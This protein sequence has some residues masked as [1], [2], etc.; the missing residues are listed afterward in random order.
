MKCTTHADKKIV[1]N[2]LCNKQ[3]NKYVNNDSVLN[4]VIVAAPVSIVV[5]FSFF[6][7]SISN[8]APYDSCYGHCNA[9][10]SSTLLI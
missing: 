3:S 8:C 2:T 9:R 7:K 1:G 6:Y 10:D 5:V 4:S